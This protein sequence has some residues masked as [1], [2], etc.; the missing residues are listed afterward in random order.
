[1]R[2]AEIL[3]VATSMN[4]AR[5]LLSNFCS[6]IKDDNE[7]VIFGFFPID[8]Q[9]QIQ[10]YGFEWT[11]DAKSYLWERLCGKILGTIILFDWSNTTSLNQ[12]K[13]I[14][15]HFESNFDFP[16][17]AASILNGEYEGL[18]SKLYRGGLSV[19]KKSRFSFFN[20]DVPGSIRELFVGLININLESRSMD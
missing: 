20:P 17:M 6:E 11:E 19:T 2:N 14:L 15:H 18:P 13:K 9:Y 7:K 8:D 3:V 10:L 12:G 4:L 5:D 1:M 16:I